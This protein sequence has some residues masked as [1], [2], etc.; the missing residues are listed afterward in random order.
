[1][2][3]FFK[4]WRALLKG[5]L[6]ITMNELLVYRFHTVF[7]M[8][9]E[10][11]F[12]VS[13]FYTVHI[14]FDFAGGTINGWSKQEGFLVS[15]IFNF[16]HQIFLTFFAS[17]VFDIGEKSGDGTFDF[18]LLKPHKPLVSIWVSTVWIAQ[19]IPCLFLSFGVMVYLMCTSYHPD[20]HWLAWFV[21]LAFIMLGVLVRLSLALLC[22]A[23]VFF[24]ERL[25]AVDTYWNLAGVGV[26]PQAVMPKALQ[27]L[28]TFGLPIFLVSSVPAEAFFGMRSWSYLLVCF[29]V[30]VAFC[31]F[32]FRVFDWALKHYKSVNAGI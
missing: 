5:N 15:S 8:I 29:L 7:Y 3:A 17:S 4:K 25:H 21:C 31:V 18:V 10:T 23:P 12:F 19:N 14:G 13:N 20:V 30:G 9:F 32:G 16:T 6:R 1:M 2:K 28:F 11:V 22:V 24:S 26:F 27:Y